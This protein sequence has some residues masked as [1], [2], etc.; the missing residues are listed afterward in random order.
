MIWWWFRPQSGDQAKGLCLTVWF[1]RVR[2]I[3]KLL[4]RFDW[5]RRLQC[6]PAKPG[7]PSTPPTPPPPSITLA[8]VFALL[9]KTG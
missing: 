1:G 7:T 3:A 9:E 8:S 4:I 6:E 2:I 5:L